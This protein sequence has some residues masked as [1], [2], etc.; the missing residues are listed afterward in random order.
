M[1]IL[2]SRILTYLNGTL[3]HDFHYKIC[4]FS[5]C[6]LISAAVSRLSLYTGR[7]VGVHNLF[8]EDDKY[9]QN[10]NHGENRCREQNRPVDRLRTGQRPEC[11]LKRIFLR[12]TEC[13]QRPDIVVP[14]PL[15]TEDRQNRYL[16]FTNREHDSHKD[17]SF[18]SAIDPR[19]F[20]ELCRYRDKELP[21]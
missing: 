14:S 13:E 17:G 4:C 19:R 1:N 16:R 21:H 10:R 2:L 18:I 15:E 9:D 5:H 3:F 20:H 12:I 7:H 11:K 6:S 8:I